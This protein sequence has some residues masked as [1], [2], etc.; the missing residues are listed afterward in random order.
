MAV[1]RNAWLGLVLVLTC[2]CAGVVP[3]INSQPTAVVLTENTARA[4]SIALHVQCPNGK[5]YVGSGFAVTPRYVITA[6]HVVNCNQAE[7]DEAY[8]PP[9]LV[10]GK[11]NTGKIVELTEESLDGPRDA[12][13]LVVVGPEEPFTST[14]KINT[15]TVQSGARVCT[16]SGYH[17]KHVCGKVK[18]VGSRRTYI[19][20]KVIPGDSGSLLYNEK[21]EV[22]GIITAYVDKAD[23]PLGVASMSTGWGYMLPNP[24]A[25]DLMDDP[26]LGPS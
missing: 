17:R 11:T 3:N 6:R 19:Y 24:E 13:L 22:V 12:A 2:T 7:D 4:A 8:E 20:M 18:H 16:W 5:K 1:L 14:V 9:M 10:V 15:D 25:L 23:P 21:G 26:S